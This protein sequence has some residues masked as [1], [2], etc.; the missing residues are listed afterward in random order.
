MNPHREP[1]NGTLVDVSKATVKAIDV[2][3][4]RVKA[5]DISKATVKAIDVSFYPV[6]VSC[7]VLAL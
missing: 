5:I 1:S 4:A 2:S 3:K 6:T 7:I